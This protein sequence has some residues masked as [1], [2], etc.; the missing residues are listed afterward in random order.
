MKIDMLARDFTPQQATLPLDLVVERYSHSVF[1]GPRR[2]TIKA[3][4][5]E[6][7]LWELIERLRCPVVF[8][9][10]KGDET[11]WGFIAD[12][13][14]HVGAWE[15][16]VNIDSM[17]NY[18][19]VA[20]A[21]TAEGQQSSGERRTTGWT[22]DA[23]SLT[24]YGRRELLHS[25]SGSSD[26]HAL[27]ARDMILAQ[28]KYPIPIIKPSSSKSAAGATL[29]CRGWYDTLDWRYYANA[30]TDLVDTATQISAIE[31]TH[32]EFIT[33]VDLD[34]TSGLA[35]SEYRDGDSTALFEIEELLKMGTS[36]YRRML[37]SVGANRRMRVYEEPTSSSL[38]LIS[39]QG[40]LYDE[41]NTLMRK[42]L[43]PVGLWA[44]LKD[45]IPGSVDI[46]KLADPTLMFIEEAEYEPATDTLKPTP[47]GLQSPWEIGRPVD[48]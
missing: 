11:W 46:T 24:E 17:R 6:N 2:A 19:A 18:I 42:E 23:D 4:G 34:V 47:R 36:N 7:D 30:G 8:Y 13:Q 16:G 20:Y 45:V 12:I 33:A 29:S 31:S 40:L 32:G 27:A 26:E 35:I 25:L 15:I 48:G 1:G 14:L 3:S 9:S 39:K 44:K 43:C 38:Y 41:L 37:A 10:D 5:E 21:Y 28:K 22:P